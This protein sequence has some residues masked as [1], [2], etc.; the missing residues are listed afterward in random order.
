M[1]DCLR[2]VLAVRN[3]Y[4]VERD[5]EPPCDPIPA[6]AP[7]RMF[8]VRCEHVIAVLPGD[9]LSCPV[10]PLGRALCEDQLLRAASDELRCRGAHLLHRRFELAVSLRC[11]IELELIPRCDRT[12]DDGAR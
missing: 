3:G 2:A 1:D 7:A 8:L 12:L 10:H 9:A 5:T 4:D 6:R 11:R